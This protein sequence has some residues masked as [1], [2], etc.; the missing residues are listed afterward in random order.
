MEDNSKEMFVRIPVENIRFEDSYEQY[1]A[2]KIKL[3][4]PEKIIDYLETALKDIIITIS[5]K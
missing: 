4:N 3:S 2:D 1:K 5:F